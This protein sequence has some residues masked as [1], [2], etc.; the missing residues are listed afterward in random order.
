MNTTSSNPLKRDEEV[1]RKE[2]HKLH[3]KHEKDRDI[4]AKEEPLVIDSSAADPV[5]PAMSEYEVDEGGWQGSTK[6][7]PGLLWA[8]IAIAAVLILVAVLIGV[9]EWS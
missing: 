7:H 6:K 4:L 2:V 8:I 9:G 3:E 5:L 1:I